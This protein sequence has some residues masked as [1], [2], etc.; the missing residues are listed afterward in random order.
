MFNPTIF[1]FGNTFSS[2]ME[3]D[4]GFPS[5][6]KRIFVGDFQDRPNSLFFPLDRFQVVSGN[7]KFFRQGDFVPGAKHIKRVVFVRFWLGMFTRLWVGID[8]RVSSVPNIIG[9]RWARISQDQL[10]HVVR[11]LDYRKGGT[12]E[13][14]SPQLGAGCLALLAAKTDQAIG[15]DRQERCSERRNGGPVIVRYTD[16]TPK[17]N[18]R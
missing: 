6:S 16:E 14:I 18:T 5:I 13:N 4:F 7:V 9:G 12:D 10:R 8:P 15:D 3:S 17:K 1:A 11:V 2:H